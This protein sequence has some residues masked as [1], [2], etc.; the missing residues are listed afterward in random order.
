MGIEEVMKKIL[1]VFGTRPEAVKMCPLILELKTRKEVEVMVCVTGQHREMLN[2]VMDVFRVVPDY[3]LA[4][5]TQNQSLFDITINVLQKLQ[6]ILKKEEPNLVM[7]HGDTSTS[8]AA[9]LAAFYQQIPVAHVE[10]GLRTYD[11][12]SPYPEEFNRQAVSLIAKYHFA[13]TQWAKKNLV[14]EGKYERQIYVTGNTVIDSVKITVKEDYRHEELEWAAD[15]KLI[16]LTAHRRENIGEPMHEMFEAVRECVDTWP[17]VRVIYPVHLNPVVRQIAG[18]H[19]QGCDRIHLIEPL[20]VVDFHNFMKRSYLILTDSGG[21]QE[22]ASALGK[23]VLVMR[24]MT[25]R[26]EGVEAGILRL[27]G[28]SKDRIL[29]ALNELL[30]DDEAYAKMS[31][32]VN[33]YGDGTASKRIA[34]IICESDC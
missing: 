20:D 9:S 29:V 23:P 2:Q 4:V 10:A 21:I 31:R 11:I 27:V 26:P 28:N 33:V 1:L 19:F 3:D 24:E 17:D 5:M 8:F 32:T 6:P 34:D 15:A 18:A 13:P 22:E 12:T 16:L 30:T 14:A 25:E 7:V